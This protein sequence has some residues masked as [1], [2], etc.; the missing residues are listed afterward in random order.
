MN[1]VKYDCD[2]ETEDIKVYHTDGNEDQF[3]IRIEPKGESWD[4]KN[5][6]IFKLLYMWFRSEDYKYPDGY[7]SSMPWFY[8]SLCFKDYDYRDGLQT[9]LEATEYEGDAQTSHFEE[10][11]VEHA[12]ELIEE[13][14]ELKEAAAED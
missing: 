12:D 5:Y 1:K 3:M 6:E 8:A 11:V 4:P 10:A 9:A 13:L 7:G 2:F 14:E